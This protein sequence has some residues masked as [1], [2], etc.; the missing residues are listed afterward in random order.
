MSNII[1]KDQADKRWIKTVDEHDRHWQERA[2]KTGY[3]NL[4]TAAIAIITLLIIVILAVT[5]G[6]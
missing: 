2:N 3:K 1:M 6:R 4:D 5:I